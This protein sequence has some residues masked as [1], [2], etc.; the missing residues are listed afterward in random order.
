MLWI[1]NLN[2]H[3]MKVE[4]MK[5]HR[6]TIIISFLSIILGIAMIFYKEYMIRELQTQ[7]AYSLIK[8]ND[9]IFWIL[10]LDFFESFFIVFGITGLLK[11]FLQKLEGNRTLVKIA[12]ACFILTILT[13]M[14]SVFCYYAYDY[15]WK[16]FI[17][18][19][20]VVN[21]IKYTIFTLSSYGFFTTFRK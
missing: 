2:S 11:A 13:M 8:Q 6:I 3:I 7:F 4:R 14:M 10:Y 1:D 15:L 9:G 5:Q 18:D 12:E 20:I 21:L 19:G 16:I 17:Y